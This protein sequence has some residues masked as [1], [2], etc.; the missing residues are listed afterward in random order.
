MAHAI[1]SHRTNS[2]AAFDNLSAT[3]S[4]VQMFDEGATPDELDASVPQ[5]KPLTG[6]S[7]D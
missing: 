3:V 6:G 5:G 7:R 1:A 4:E 2:L